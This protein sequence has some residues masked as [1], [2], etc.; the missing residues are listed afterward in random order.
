MKKILNLLLVC[1]TLLSVTGEVLGFNKSY[2]FSGNGYNGKI[3]VEVNIDGKD[4]QSVKVVSHKESSG[5]SDLPIKEIPE[6]IVAKQ[7]LN[8][9]AISGATF[10]SFGILEAVEHAVLAAG[11]N[12]DAYQGKEKRDLVSLSDEEADIVVI[13]AGGAGMAAALEAKRDSD[14]NVILLEKLSMTGGSTGVS[15]GTIWTIGSKY[16]K[17]HNIDMSPDDL[18]EFM[19]LR[20]GGKINKN[21]VKKMGE[22]S[23]SVIEKYVDSGMPLNTESMRYVYSPAVNLG[24]MS[25]ENASSG[26]GG[27]FLMRWLEEEVKDHGVD[28]RLN[29]PVKDLIIEDGQ[30]KGVV[31]NTKDGSYEIKAKKVIIAS[32]GFTR[33]RSLIAKLAPEHKGT[34][35][36]TGAGSNGDG[37]IMTE[38]LNPEIVGEGMM[39]LRG[40]NDRFGYYNEIGSLVNVSQF[41]VNKDGRRFANERKFYSEFYLDINAQPGKEVYGLID[42]STSRRD[43][44]EAALE[45]GVVKKY[46]SIDT[47]ASELGFDSEVIESEIVSYND[48]YDSGKDGQFGI[49]NANMTPVKKP[50]FYVVTIRPT[51][52][53]SIPGLKVNDQC[54]IMNLDGNTIDNLYGAGELIMGNVFSDFYVASG[55]GVATAIYTG[56]IAGTEARRS[57]D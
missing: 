17:K 36:Y 28:L 53:G 10:T 55:T 2:I 46:A 31:V 54:N 32:G 50:P 34:T 19:N 40:I 16:N 52:I 26:K 23:G 43:D 48:A 8:I 24:G 29:S 6:K 11:L 13:G 56:Y 51:L 49:S 42:S 35:P 41:I 14:L 4:I 9:D 22:I 33:N 44:L 3:K 15:G 38:V 27:N 39:G 18:V 21:L 45:E 30:V 5:V 7:S 37:F 20:S 1:F 25:P 47:L 12:I 57:L